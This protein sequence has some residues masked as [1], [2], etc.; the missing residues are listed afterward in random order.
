MS[1][2]NENLQK[3]NLENQVPETT[4]E[5]AVSEETKTDQEEQEKEKIIVTPG[6]IVEYHAKGSSSLPFAKKSAPAMVV[7]VSEN[8]VHLNVFTPDFNPVK[9]ILDVKHAS[10]AS[11]NEHCWD[12]FPKV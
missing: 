3:E 9:A 6:R 5:T 8:S 12:W 1:E 11:E 10:V 7:E 4:T 2:E